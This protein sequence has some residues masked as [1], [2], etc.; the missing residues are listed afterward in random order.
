M[1][2]YRNRLIRAY[3]GASNPKRAPNPFTGFDEGDNIRMARALAAKAGRLAA[4]P[5]RQHRAQRGQRE[6]ARLAGAQGGVVHRDAAALRLGGRRL[7]YRDTRAVRRHGSAAASSLGTALAISGAAA[8]P[9][10]G[11]HSSPVVT[12]LLTLFNVRLGWW[13]GNPGAA[14]D[15]HLSTTEGPRIAIRPFV[16]EMFGLTTDDSRLRLSL[17]R[18][19]LRESRALR[20]DPPALPLHRRQRCGLRSGLRLRGSRQCGAQD[21]DRSRRLHRASASCTNSRQRV[22]GQR[23]DRGRL[24]R[25]RRDRL[26]DRAGVDPRRRARGHARRTATSSTSN[27]AI[28]APKAPASSPTPTANAAFPH[29]TTADQFFSRVAVRKLPHARLRDHGWRVEGSGGER[30]YYRRL[31]RSG[32]RPRRHAPNSGTASWRSSP[33]SSAM[34]HSPAGRIRRSSRTSSAR[35]TIT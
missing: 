32:S 22:E 28:T 8:S 35:W 15:A 1:S 7:G 17:R 27:R 13:L 5:R 3:L 26:Q 2:I 20:D 21:R 25:D 19:A 10:M 18:R 30:R 11:Y 34:P 16:A 14:G 29:E 23:R 31:R 4:V 33:S 24:L 6:A 12:L 9:N